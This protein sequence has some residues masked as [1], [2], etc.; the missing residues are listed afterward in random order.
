MSTETKTVTVEL[1]VEAAYAQLVGFQTAVKAFRAADEADDQDARLEAAN[2]A[3]DSCID[4]INDVVPYELSTELHSRLETEH[5][6]LVDDDDPMDGL[7]EALKAMFGEDFDLSIV[8]L[9]EEGK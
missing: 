9:K 1:S 5:P 6:E 4:L 3:V 2:A 8:G 7:A